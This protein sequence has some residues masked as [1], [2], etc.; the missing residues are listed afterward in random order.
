[1]G[2][3]DDAGVAQSAERRFAVNKPEVGR[4]DSS[5]PHRV[6][7]PVRRSRR[8]L[9]NRRGDNHTPGITWGQRLG[10]PECPYARRWVLNLGRFGSLRVHHWVASDDQRFPHDHAWW[11]LTV[12]LRGGYTDISDMTSD[13]V[14]PS[15]TSTFRIHDHVRAPAVRFRSAQHRHKVK[16]DHDGAWTVLL[17]GPPVRDWGF[18]VDGQFKRMRQYFREHGHHPCDG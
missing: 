15:T 10:E 18:W 9:I 14:P 4:F 8:S 2:D 16:V 5:P 17:T 12:V 13:W 11:F 1:M 7:R 6:H 3:A